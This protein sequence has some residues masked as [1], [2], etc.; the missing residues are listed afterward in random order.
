[1]VSR[2]GLIKKTIKG[3]KLYKFLLLY[4]V[5]GPKR[6]KKRL[7]ERKGLVRTVSPRWRVKVTSRRERGEKGEAPWSRSLAD[8]QNRAPRGCL[9]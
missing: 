8:P 3:D 2:E 6:I 1:M 9:L 7:S 5:K 4:Q